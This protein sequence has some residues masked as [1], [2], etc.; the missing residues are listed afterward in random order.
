ML[1][2]MWRQ[3]VLAILVYA[4]YT[5]C[6]AGMIVESDCLIGTCCSQ[7]GEQDSSNRSG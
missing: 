4:T 7:S 6:G 1:D 5:N 2:S 3:Y